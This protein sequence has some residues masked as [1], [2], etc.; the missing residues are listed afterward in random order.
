MGGPSREHDFMNQVRNPKNKDVDYI[1][2]QEDLDSKNNLEGIYH[3]SH[4]ITS[5]SL[6]PMINAEDILGIKPIKP[7]T[8][9]TYTGTVPPPSRPGFEWNTDELFLQKDDVEVLKNKVAILEQAVEKLI[10]QGQRR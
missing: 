4:G 6:G 9:T 2:N 8:I 1:L 7:G 10:M 5:T 3:H